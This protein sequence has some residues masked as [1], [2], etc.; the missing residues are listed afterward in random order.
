MEHKPNLPTTERKSGLSNQP[1]LFITL[2]MGLC[3]V[4]VGRLFWLQVWQGSRYRELAD[5]NRIRLI[6]R[7]PL[8]GR[9]LDRK[10]EVLATSRLTYNLYLQPRLVSVERWDALSESLSRLLNIPR[11]ALNKR[12]KEGLEKQLYRITLATDLKINQVLR[13]EEQRSTFKGVQVDVDFLRYYP[14]ATLASH[15]LGYTQLI[16]KDEYKWLSKKGYLIRDRIGR[17]GI[18][19]AFEDHLRGQWGGQMLEVDAMGMVQ[20]NLGEKTAISGRDLTLTLDFELQLA[21]EKALSDKKA[22]AIVA[23]DPRDGSIL[24][25]AS[26]PTFN[27]NFFSRFVLNQ[28]EYNNLFFSSKKPLLSRAINAY[29]PGSTFKLVTGMAGM[30]TGKFPPEVLLTTKKCITYGS[31]CFPDHNGKGFGTIGYED[32]LRFSS[33]TFFYQVGVGVGSNALYEAAVKLGFDSPTGSELAYEENNGLVGHEKWAAQGRDWSAPGSTPWMLEDMASASIGQSV[34]QVTPLQLARAYAV[35]A[36]GGYLVTPH[37]VNGN[38]DWLSPKKKKKVVI[39]HTTYETLRRG[40]L[41]VVQAGTGYAINVST[42][43][44]VAGK[45]G[46][47]EDSSGGLDH[48]WFVCFA[49]FQ[50]SEIV[51]VAF[52][53]NT[54]G[55]GSVHALPMARSVLEVWNANRTN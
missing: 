28:K 48:A 6:A 44:P 5:E 45:S 13:F 49:P 34:V 10:G 39:K 22:G 18:E 43:P 12:R 20:R 35:F 55:G 15:V 9:L 41:K 40:L 36:N 2:V 16:T 23:L 25:M 53:Q 42:L 30:E 29:D 3:F 11:D 8:R 50:A 38:T 14:H 31:H 1:T 4:M 19:A 17:R 33:N 26:R 21:A 54:P 7:S 32:A 24:A 52:A 27:P 47:A 51:V 37:L 46:T